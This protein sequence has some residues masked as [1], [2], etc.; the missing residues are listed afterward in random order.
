MTSNFTFAAIGSAGAS[1]AWTAGGWG[2]I[3]A[4][5]G[6]LAV[7]GLLAWCLEHV[8]TRGARRDAATAAHAASAAPAAA[9]ETIA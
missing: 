1:W 8:Q 6:G 7:V 2:A 3:S 4:L 5:G 9:H